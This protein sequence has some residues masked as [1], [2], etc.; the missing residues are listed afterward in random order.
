MGSG[1]RSSITPRERKNQTACIQWLWRRSLIAPWGPPLAWCARV[2]LRFECRYRQRK[3]TEADPGLL[4]V[5]S[6][7]QG[8]GK[9]RLVRVI[10]ARPS[11]RQVLAD[12]VTYSFVSGSR[13]MY[14]ARWLWWRQWT[15]CWPKVSSNKRRIVIFIS[16][17]LSTTKIADRIF[18]IEDGEVIEQGSHNE[19]MSLD[20]KYAEMFNVQAQKYT[21]EWFL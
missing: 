15:N 13:Q 19:L 10:V 17:R 2:L 3:L 20:G 6:I 16:H 4:S 1:T 18:Y 11:H 21:V 9:R 8:G 7:D 14:S 5:A 12:R